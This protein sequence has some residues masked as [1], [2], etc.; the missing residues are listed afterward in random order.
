MASACRRARQ[1]R[2]AVCRDVIAVLVRT[3]FTLDGVAKTL[4]GEY[5][6]ALQLR[7]HC[8]AMTNFI[9]RAT[10]GSYVTFNMQAALHS[11]SQETKT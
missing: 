5:Q 10:M 9:W 7:Q 11:W 2:V 8:G 3:T 1:C 4:F 6:Y